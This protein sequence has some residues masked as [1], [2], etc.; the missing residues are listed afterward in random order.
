MFSI[1]GMC[2]SLGL[3]CHV[4]WS[5]SLLNES[6]LSH[7]YFNIHFDIK[8]IFRKDKLQFSIQHDD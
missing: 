8:Y 4:C 3:F 7:S 1:F 5:I 6:V 2:P